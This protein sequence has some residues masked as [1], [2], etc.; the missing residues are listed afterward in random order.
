[1]V[2]IADISKPSVET[3]SGVKTSQV[4]SAKKI[5]QPEEIDA[6]RKTESSTRQAREPKDKLKKAKKQTVEKET[7]EDTP[8]SQDD[9]VYD[10]KGE[11]KQSGRHIDLKV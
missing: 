11:S 6:T 10:S 8:E 1:M 5:E 9:T 3:K 4:R 2:N 7:I